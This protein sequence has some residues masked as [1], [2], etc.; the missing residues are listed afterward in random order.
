MLFRSIRKR[1]VATLALASN[2][3]PA[4]REHMF[5]E[6][7]KSTPYQQA[8]ETFETRGPV[9]GPL[10][11]V[12]ELHWITSPKRYY[13]LVKAYGAIGHSQE[14]TAGQ[15]KIADQ[16]YPL[17]FTHVL[18]DKPARFPSQPM[19]TSYVPGTH[20]KALYVAQQ[21]EKR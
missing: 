6:T 1:G 17:K 4:A 10:S 14:G 11:G 18:V 20:R 2:L 15:V 21:V 12:F 13:D 16:A 9:Q 19:L 8:L 3:P 7:L 5:K